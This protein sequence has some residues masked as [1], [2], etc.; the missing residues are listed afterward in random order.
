MIEHHSRTE[1]VPVQGDQVRLE[2]VD[3]EPGLVSVDVQ[4]VALQQLLL[5]PPAL[6][7]VLGQLLHLR[8]GGGV[9][10]CPSVGTACLSD[11][12]GCKTSRSGYLQFVLQHDVGEISIPFITQRRAEITLLS[13]K[14]GRKRYVKKKKPKQYCASREMSYSISI[15]HHP[16]D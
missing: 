1:D 9:E 4:A 7:P 3:E 13:V 16:E 8:R 15:C 5:V 2:G 14:R 12:L 10:T 6:R 11:A